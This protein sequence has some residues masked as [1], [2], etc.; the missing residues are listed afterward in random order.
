LFCSRFLN[1]LQ[2]RTGFDRGGKITLVNLDDAVHALKVDQ[3]LFAIGNRPATASGIAALRDNRDV[4][5]GTNGNCLGDFLGT[6][7]KQDDFGMAFKLATRL[8]IMGG[9]NVAFHA[10][11]LGAQQV[12]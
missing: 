7:R 11:T 3:D 6:G 2:D 4:M 1:G 12:L 8:S 10:E 9:Q 5:G